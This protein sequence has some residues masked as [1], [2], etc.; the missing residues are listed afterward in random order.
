MN[1]MGLTQEQKKALSRLLEYREMPQYQSTPRRSSSGKGRVLL[2]KLSG[3]AGSGKTYTSTALVEELRKD[4]PYGIH[5]IAPTH[6]AKNQLRKRGWSAART[7]HS[8]L[9]LKV[10]ESESGTE[11]IQSDR[12]PVIP[13]KGI[14]LI[15]EAGMLDSSIVGILADKI[16]GAAREF[17]LIGF[18]LAI[19]LLYDTNQ[20]KPVGETDFPF[21]ELGA[22]LASAGVEVTEIDSYLSTPIRFQGTP[23]EHAVNMVLDSVP[24]PEF[25]ALSSLTEFNSRDDVEGAFF[26]AIPKQSAINVCVQGFKHGWKHGLL[27]NYQAITYTH[28][29]R[30]ALNREI[31]ERIGLGQQDFAVGEI[32]TCISPIARGDTIV[33]PTHARLAV[34]A[35][36]EEQVVSDMGVSVRYRELEVVETAEGHNFYGMGRIPITA[37]CPASLLDWDKMLKQSEKAV[38]EG[39][40]KWIEH[41]RLKG[42]VDQVEHS[43]AC[44]TYAA[45]GSTIPYVF[46]PSVGDFKH[47][48]NRAIYTAVSRVSRGLCLGL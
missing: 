30:R 16:V 8:H 2:L 31:R 5:V 12:T 35:V 28:R 23:A 36:G 9:G 13:S 6:Q 22:K 40:R 46:I 4:Y 11:L 14:L 26:Y 24:Q 29:K 33:A 21:L 39:K 41:A 3:C 10:Q 38:K 18:S 42:V 37:V 19:I 20:L 32:L 17:P 25:P 1:L 48:E 47:F 43:Y 44:T 15:D 45:Q 27:H 34:W 7:V